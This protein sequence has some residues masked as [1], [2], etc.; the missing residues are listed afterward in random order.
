[1]TRT[2]PCRLLLATL[3]GILLLFALFP[4]GVVAQSAETHL[5]L[6]NTQRNNVTLHFDGTS[7]MLTNN[8]RQG[9]AA[10][11]ARISAETITGD[12]LIID[13]GAGDDTLTLNFDK[14]IPNHDIIFNGGAQ[15][16]LTGDVLA[17]VGDGKDDRAIYTPD[18]ATFGDGVVQV[19]T[20]ARGTTRTI[21]FTGLEPVDISG[22][23]NATLSLPGADDVLTIAEGFDDATGAIPAIVVSGT[24]GGVA[25]EQVAFF[26][27]TTVAIDTT[28]SD[29]DD[30]ITFASGANDHNNTNLVINTGAGTDV[31]N[32]DGDVTT[33][34]AQ[35]Y[36]QP[37]VVNGDVT[38][39]ASEID[40]A[41]GADSVSGTNTLSLLPV[42]ADAN[43][44]LGGATD[45]GA[46]ILDITAS[47]LAALADGFAA[48]VIGAA[49]GTGT[50][51]IPATTFSDPVSFA[52]GAIDIAGHLNAGANDVTLS[53]DTIADSNSSGTDITG[54]LTINGG[55]TPGSS[56]G[57][58]IVDGDVTL[59][60]TDIF[61]VE[62]GGTTAGTEYDQL[63]VTGANRTVTLG[64][65][66]L[67]ATLI[68]AF[69][70]TVG[71]L[72]TIVDLVDGSSVVAGTFMGLGE[73]AVV[74]AS[75]T[76]LL[77]SYVGGDGND[78]T[79]A[80]SD[81]ITV[82]NDLDSGAGSLREAIAL[83]C[84]GGTINF[85]AGLSGG[86]IGLNSALIIEKDLTINGLGASNLTVD[87]QINDRVFEVFTHTVAI[88]GLSVTGGIGVTEP[89]GGIFNSGN[90]TLDDV[91]V[92]LNVAIDEFGGGIANYNVLTITNSAVFSNT[93][94]GAD[95][96]GIYN[97]GT[98][99]LDT[100]DVYA[101][102]APPAAFPAGFGGGIA[103]A[104][105]ATIT[106]SNIF[107][108]FSSIDGGGIINAGDLTITASEIYGNGAIEGFG[109][110]IASF[111]GTVIISDTLIYENIA[112]GGDGG[113]LYNADVLQV[114]NSQ[115]Y[116]NT[117]ALD[118]FDNFGEGGGIA[119][120]GILTVTNS[121]IYGNDADSFGAGISN[122]AT[123]TVTG[124][125]IYDNITFEGDGGG[126][127][128]IGDL[129]LDDV[130]IYLNESID[131]GISAGG[132]IASGG[133]LTITNSAV[134]SNTTEFYGGGIIN[135]FIA[136]M[137][138]TDVY[139]N[140]VLEGNGGGISDF[141]I[142][143]I[144]TSNIFSNTAI[145]DAFGD[146]GEGGGI[147]AEGFVLT[148]TNSTVYGNSAENDGGGIDQYADEAS[149]SN[150][151]IR[152]NTSG[153]DGGGID[154]DFGILTLDNVT[155]TA[156]EAVDN[157]GGIDID[158]DANINA[159]DITGNSAGND[160]GGIDFAD[161]TLIITDTQI[162]TNT[163]AGEGGGI[164]ADDV[165]S[166]SG[167]AINANQALAG[168]G[169]FNVDH[170]TLDSVTVQENSVTFDGGGIWSDD[171]ITVTNSTVISNSAD[172]G[173][174][175][176]LAFDQS[177]GN[178]GLSTISDS[179]INANSA[180][181]SGGGF[182]NITGTLYI[183]SS[184]IISN[185][186][187][188][189]GGGLF[190]TGTVTATVAIT[191]SRIL[192]NSAATG[193]AYQQ[194]HGT[195]TIN[196]S[197]IVANDDLAVN[198]VDGT[199]VDATDNWWGHPSGPSGVQ[200]G[201]GDSVSGN[202]TVTGF[203]T[204]AILGCPQLGDPEV[205]IAKTVTPTSV[206][207]GETVTF[208]LTFSN[209]GSNQ[210][211]GV[212]ITDTVPVSV[213]VTDV[214]SSVYGT[215][216][217][218]G[219]VVIT[220][221]SDYVWSVS[222]LAVNAGGIITMTGI[223]SDDV[224]LIGTTIT[225][226]AEISSTYDVLLG[227][228]LTSA[229]FE[230][231]GVTIGISPTT[232]TEDETTNLTYTFTRTGSTAAPLTVSFAVSGTATF[233]DDYT[234]SGASTFTTTA[235]T[236]LFATGQSTT[237]VV[238]DPS[239]DTLVEADEFVTL[240]LLDTTGYTVSTPSAATGFIQNDDI[241]Y[242]NVNEPSVLEG[243]SGTT[244]LIF[245]L[246]ITN[247]VDIEVPFNYEATS[248]YTTIVFIPPA[249][250]T[251]VTITGTAT[252]DVDYI[253]TSGTVTFTG[254]ANEMIDVIVSVVG[255]EFVENDE[256]LLFVIAPNIGDGGRAVSFTPVTTGTILN[257]D[258]ADVTVA[259]TVTPP[260][261]GTNEAITYTLEFSNVGTGLATGVVLTDA[262]PSA[263][264]V[265][266][267]ISSGVA[268]TQTSSDP[269]V[270][271]SADLLPNTGG[272]ITITG[273]V[274]DD[275]TLIG[276]TITNSVSITATNDFTT[277]NNS[278][279][280]AFDVVGV[281]VTVAPSSVNED[282][283]DVL[284]YTFTR[285]GATADPLAVTFDV[286]G[287]ATF[288]GDY[289]TSGATTFDGASGSVT[290]AA[291][292]STASFAV[293]PSADTLVELSET[294][295]ISLTDG[296]GYSVST[297]DSATG[298]IDN[299]DSAGVTIS[300]VSALEGDT[301]TV[302]LVFAVTLTNAV[303]AAVSVT[304]TTADD[305][306]TVADNDYAANGG[307]I[308]FPAGSTGTQQLIV[309]VNGD[310]TVEA[311]ETF[312]VTLTTVDA[313][314]HNVTITDADGIGTIE[315]DDD[316]TAI[317]AQ[318]ADQNEGDA[319]ETAFTFVISRTGFDSGVNSVAYTVTGAGSDPANADDFGGVFPS[320][321]ITFG[322]GVT[323]TLTISVTGDLTIEP[324]EQFNVT[325]SHVTR[326]LDII[327]A[328]AQGIIRNDDAATVTLS[329]GTAQNEGNGGATSFVFTATLGAAVTKPF[330]IAYA[331]N[332][333]TA[334]SADNDYN[335]SDGSLTFVGNAGEM[336]TF[337]VSVNGDLKVEADETFSV[338]L[339][340][341]TGAL[342][343]TISVDGSPQVSTITNDD[344]AALSIVDVTVD[345]GVGSALVT[346]TLSAEST[347]TTTATY[348]TSDDSATAG[349]DYTTSSG[350][351]TITAGATQAVIVVPIIDD[352]LDENG[353]MFDVLLNNPD[354]AMIADGT[355]VVTILD[356]DAQPTIT[357]SNQSVSEADGSLTITFTLSAASGLPVGFDY[358]TVD[359]S[360]TAPSDYISAT[361]RLTFT[362]GTT[363]TTTTITIV[364]D[365]I[366][367]NSETFIVSLSNPSNAQTRS[368]VERVY[369]RTPL[370]V[371]TI[372][373]D[374][375]ASVNVQPTNLV[376]SEGASALFTI[377]LATQPTAAVSITV[378]SGDATECTVAPNPV[379]LDPS[380]WQ[381][382]ISVTVTG[383]QDGEVD[384]DQPCLVAV[385]SISS[386]DPFYAPLNPTDVSVLVQDV[387][388]TAVTL[389]MQYAHT[390][391]RTL[392]LIA[393]L[394][395]LI[396]TIIYRPVPRSGGA[397]R[398]QKPINK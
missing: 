211:G 300:D 52:G 149:I 103:T 262:L 125:D 294:V 59:S 291:G 159:S 8:L 248:E 266:S 352:T 309:T 99:S 172:L 184:D 129:T 333:G 297:P 341:V 205:G 292:M 213:T 176:Y 47:D 304:Y 166:I 355:G 397:E 233:G 161:G 179:T 362:A 212:T 34:G 236:V 35:T 60:S 289:L 139:G 349:D 338:T 381:T 270:W 80:C 220:Q 97:E 317:A 174:G 42:S 144:D 277:T 191:N 66:T 101:N 167:G 78:V 113:G 215:N 160:G 189:S 313:S 335:D 231:V 4:R 373:N 108:N 320:G 343:Q 230:V 370:I 121:I 207:T 94:D 239:A 194:A 284:T 389:S 41:G 145:A 96:G 64:D 221:T 324:D 379:V 151:V 18:R 131:S 152:N 56:P 224:T 67:D 360:A 387:G 7:Y 368:G 302:N 72:F 173:G 353:E 376:L 196:T 153:D 135:G 154:H 188:T 33:D 288:G 371:V 279:S 22:M 93:V 11:V 323:E 32:L 271:Q 258:L 63:Q 75:G 344:I 137:A 87:G 116:S 126:I 345:E 326:N 310:T 51:T 114:D 226:T 214:V 177:I 219:S 305:S 255:D 1:M 314:G 260:T 192:S 91:A 98:L 73:G 81:T 95:G 348:A 169:L 378:S 13:G 89:G 55:L 127:G 228:N 264:Q 385:G 340:A 241:A 282:G 134:F 21:T 58:T 15:A 171:Y 311:D 170:A 49:N 234:Q 141:G 244:D 164:W 339:G 175:F 24:S 62:V 347:F 48:V 307:S 102:E 6:S 104:G 90:L 359:G 38:L 227:N 2:H 367:E 261:V 243:D 54:N 276:T 337:V 372:T 275:V 200:P 235:G 92:Y 65:A 278:A 105:T 186:A 390:S 265:T 130:N 336:Q 46:A 290:F 319:G 36:N 316:D 165:V 267:V 377:T 321:T 257:D 202:V 312:S 115:I 20:D 303:D 382:G 133:V 287:T 208:T 272:T 31:L 74:T 71:E 332:D 180:T 193:G 157:G 17:I 280:A 3:F 327:T 111:I 88:S 119:S 250:P 19:I 185:V 350:T 283:A 57:Q 84:P 120:D 394:S 375:I 308:D 380:N 156:N 123:A 206:G 330:S 68:N 384:G 388:V 223:V 237:T 253:T 30:T 162:L 76:N 112:D 386:A 331:T 396:V 251:L 301:G 293:D 238:I 354:G 363:Q 187:A 106:N 14:S 366:A 218:G 334:T 209:T 364:N 240:T 117:A 40:F 365:D 246:T 122:N 392:L 12:T 118:A 286:G 281:S 358:T 328:T 298:T 45:S 29:G 132:G 299:D 82:Q 295:V 50:I 61:T 146:F 183:T 158:D 222:P 23:A 369:L 256:T 150:T 69:T 37:I 268:I 322:S 361:G 217:T 346:V 28:N 232:V 16:T 83:I 110:G 242:I 197:C 5:T 190:S 398:F 128:N 143:S 225:N 263:I 296:S 357:A 178:A 351:I 182:Y 395:L 27:N 100:V 229:D 245:T 315:N 374:D 259:K 39:T 356:N 155:I 25:I 329:G 391:N 147:A 318:N 247:D 136:T 254:A 199:T 85:A 9:R 77:I 163:A 306:A 138:G 325:L 285:T 107:N 198:Y 26:N 269:T 43:I 216:A 181:T 148:M 249:G 273:I 195:T 142:L 109:G 342:S 168:G 204:A 70:P 140:V 10:L 44:T 393:T 203:H 274:S 53:A 79:L 210:S 252:A 201:I 383:V 124:T 86:T